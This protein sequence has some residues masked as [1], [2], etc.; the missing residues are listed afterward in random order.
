MREFVKHVAVVP[1][2]GTG[3]AAYSTGDSI[4]FDDNY[5]T[6][7]V[8]IHEISHSL[9]GHAR[10]D[11]APNGFSQSNIWKD[12]YNQ[13]SAVVSAYARTSWAENFAET[14]IIAVYDKVVPGGIGGIQPNWNAVR[15]LRAASS[16]C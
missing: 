7:G 3:A 14:A 11:V 8:M 16:R 1:N 9:D 13:D 5:L 12:N 4:L 15:L 10:R 6:N 2:I